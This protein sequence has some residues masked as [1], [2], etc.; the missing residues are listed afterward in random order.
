MVAGPP[1]SLSSQP[2]QLHQAAPS[3]SV[4]MESHTETK[5]RSISVYLY[6]VRMGRKQ[7]TGAIA[8]APSKSTFING[9]T[10]ESV[11]GA[12]LLAAIQAENP[13]P[14]VPFD[15][16]EK[17]AREYLADHLGG[18]SGGSRCPYFMVWHSCLAPET[19]VPLPHDTVQ[20]KAGPRDFHLVAFDAYAWDKDGGD[21]GQGAYVLGTAATQVMKKKEYKKRLDWARPD[22]GFMRGLVKYTGYL[23]TRKMGAT[24]QS[25]S[26]FDDPRE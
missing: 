7:M 13:D 12:S 4:G 14:K 15:D 8:L 2:L 6:H 17:S 9:A 24:K 1:Y 26:R 3:R 23:F 16:K 22:E 10:D 20:T 18:G 25:L 19:G 21:E 11:I 5:S